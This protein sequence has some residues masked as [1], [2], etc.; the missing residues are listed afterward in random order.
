MRTICLLAILALIACGCSNTESDTPPAQQQSQATGGESTPA[1][2]PGSGEP[3][4]PAGETA[5]EGGADSPL[6]EYVYPG[7]ELDGE[8]AMG[9][10]V[11]IAYRTDDPLA[12][13]AEFYEGT[14][15]DAD[16]IAETRAYFSRDSPEGA[17]TV[18]LTPLGDLTQIILKLEKAR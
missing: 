9:N 5:E 8:M 18:T 6:G 12:T 13:V 3:G 17:I 7:A 1:T 14:S 10:V 16:E 4:A 11:S 2:Q 15:L